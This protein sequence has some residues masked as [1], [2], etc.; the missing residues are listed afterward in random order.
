MKKNRT[1]CQPSNI[2]SQPQ[3]ILFQQKHHTKKQAKK[4]EVSSSDQSSG[5]IKD[6]FDYLTP[7]IF[8]GTPMVESLN[9]AKSIFYQNKANKKIL[10]IL[11]DGIPTSGDPRPIARE[12]CT[13]GV[14]V[15]TCFLTEKEIQTPKQ[16][17]DNNNFDFAANEGATTLFKMSSRM[18]NT[19][20]PV[21]YFVDAGWELPTSG[22]SKLFLQANS[23]DLVDEFCKIIFSHMENNTCVDALIDILASISVADYI[24]VE[25]SK[26][27]PKDQ[28]GKTCYAN[29][30]AAVYHLAMCRIVDR[31]GEVLK[32]ED[33]LQ[34]VTIFDEN[35]GG[36]TKFVIERTCSKYDLKFTEVDEKHARIALNE[37]RPVITT[38]TFNNRQKSKFGEFFMNYPRGILKSENFTGWYVQNIVQSL[39]IATC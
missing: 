7:F 2:L 31:E 36:N 37:R 29:A 33:I 8:G 21:S 12:L 28:S 14:T 39:A 17:M 27:V 30:I 20:A 10:F 22:E 25:N 1:S 6:L 23:L 34:E 35:V 11:S 18:H 13:L 5:K 16:L 3:Q 4:L 32:F 19:K 38:F 26:F 15:V 24:N 9:H